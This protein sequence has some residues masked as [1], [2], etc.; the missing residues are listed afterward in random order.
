MRAKLHRSKHLTRSRSGVTGE[1]EGQIGVSTI[2]VSDVESRHPGDVLDVR[3]MAA[4]RLVEHFTRPV[5]RRN[6]ARVSTHLSSTG[7]EKLVLWRTLCPIPRLRRLEGL[8]RF[9][10]EHSVLP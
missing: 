7:L 9:E 8:R 4:E 1:D 10:V 2:D 5:L 6:F 3:E